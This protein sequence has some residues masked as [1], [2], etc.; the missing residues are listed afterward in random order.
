MTVPEPL[1]SPQSP[2]TAETMSGY[3]Q[4]FLGAWSTAD[5][6]D[7]EEVEECR[8]LLEVIPPNSLSS[9]DQVYAGG[10]WW[11]FKEIGVR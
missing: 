5:Q 8:R 11:I 3:G 4:T 6:L 10:H 2:E 9:G 7:V 1:G